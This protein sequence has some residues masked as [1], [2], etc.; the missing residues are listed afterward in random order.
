MALT[1]LI[2]GFLM[3]IG[4]LAWVN[5]WIPNRGALP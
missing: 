5:E 1:T 3:F 2:F 4:W